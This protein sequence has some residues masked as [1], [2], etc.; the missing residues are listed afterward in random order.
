MDFLNDKGQQLQATEIKCGIHKFVIAAIPIDDW[1]AK[2]ARI[3]AQQQIEIVPGLKVSELA[4]GRRFEVLSKPEGIMRNVSLK[5][6]TIN[7]Y[8]QTPTWV[9]E[10]KLRQKFRFV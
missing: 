3:A 5:D 9:T 10:D 4:T 2:S 6:L 8:R 1:D 7:D